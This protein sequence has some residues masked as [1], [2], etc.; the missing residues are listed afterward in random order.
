MQISSRDLQIIA[1]VSRFGQVTLKHIEGHFFGSHK[2]NTSV[3]VVLRRLVNQKLLVRVERRTVGGANGGSG[4]YVY[5]LGYAGW[6]MSDSKDAY[7]QA[8][9]VNYHSLAIVETFM[10]IHGAQNEQTQ[11]I[12]YEVD[13]ESSVKINYIPINPDLYLELRLGSVERRVWVEV[14]LGTERPKQLKD[15]LSRYHEAWKDAPDKWNPWPLVVWVLP[16]E[17]RKA[18]LDSLIAQQPKESQPMYRTATFENVAE[19]VTR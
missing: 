11:I 14:D 8:R 5:I 7:S 4:Q 3:K 9:T 6:R 19:V 1:F 17:K 10:S 13:E 18:E 15:K 12:R 16:D 2:S